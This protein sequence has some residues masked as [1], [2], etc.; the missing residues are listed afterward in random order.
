MITITVRNVQNGEVT[1]IPLD[2]IE[3]VVK[4]GTGTIVHLRS[5]DYVWCEQ[6]LDEV[7][8]MLEATKAALE[9]KVLFHCNG[10]QKTVDWKEIKMIKKAYMAYVS[11]SLT[12]IEEMADQ[13]EITMNDGTT[14]LTDERKRTIV[15][16]YN[17]AREVWKDSK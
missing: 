3:K 2:A 6:S 11:F 13:A 9:Q 10:V 15:D 12:D 14:Y 4:Q 17:M 8:E 5:G 16:R 7:Q 1:L